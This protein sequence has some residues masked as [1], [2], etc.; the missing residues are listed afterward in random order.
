MSGECGWVT[1]SPESLLPRDSGCGCIRSHQIHPSPPSPPS[2]LP[3]VSHPPLTNTNTNT[4]TNN[5]IFLHNSGRLS[6]HSFPFADS[7]PHPLS[8]RPCLRYLASAPPP[9]GLVA[10]FC[11][12]LCCGPASVLPTDVPIPCAKQSLVTAAYRRS[13]NLSRFPSPWEESVP[14]SL[15]ISLVNKSSV[16]RWRY[17]P[18]RVVT[19]LPSC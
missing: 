3:I 12:V 6:I 17:L 4:N 7:I 11:S 18:R 8:L 10:L 14:C 2:L 13:L 9:C 19:L 1:G 15:I 16:S 5:N